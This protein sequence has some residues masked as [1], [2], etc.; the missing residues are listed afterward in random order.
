MVIKNRNNKEKEIQN[1]S[2]C[3]IIPFEFVQETLLKNDLN[4][5]QQ[6]INDIEIKIQKI[7]EELN[8]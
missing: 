3:R 1:G 7:I 5:L 2:S 8:K 6:K 4:N